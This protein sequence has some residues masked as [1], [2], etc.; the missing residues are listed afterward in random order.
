MSVRAVRGFEPETSGLGVE[1]RR[2]YGLNSSEN[3]SMFQIYTE[4]GRALQ[5]NGNQ[6]W[7]KSGDTPNLT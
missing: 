1:S 4:D 3:V 5:R 2:K 7:S 6:L